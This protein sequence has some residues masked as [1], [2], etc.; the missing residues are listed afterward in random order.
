MLAGTFAYKCHG[1]D[2]RTIVLDWE[3]KLITAA[4]GTKYQGAYYLSSHSM[5]PYAQEDLNAMTIDVLRYPQVD[6]FWQELY[7]LVQTKSDGEG[8]C[9]YFKRV[10]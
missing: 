4:D 3:K 10:D 8:H 1:N 7:M 5:K 2:A 9:V 6:V